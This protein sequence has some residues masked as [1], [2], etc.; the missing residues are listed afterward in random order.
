[1]ASTGSGDWEMVGDHMHIIHFK[2][3]NGLFEML[4]WLME[5][6]RCVNTA[7]LSKSFGLCP[8]THIISEFTLDGHH[9]IRLLLDHFLYIILLRLKFN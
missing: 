1:M 3:L 2:N 8:H 6:S 7:S 4:F 5:N 9:A